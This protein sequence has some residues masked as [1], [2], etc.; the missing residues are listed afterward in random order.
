MAVSVQVPSVLLPYCAGRSELSVAAGTVRSALDEIEREHPRLY[1]CLCDETRRLR[2]HVNVFVNS[3]IVPR[4]EI[5][6]AKLT[7]GDV[8]HV[9]QAVSG[10]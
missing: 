4:G 3:A 9:F 6:S 2:P 10:G 7:E 5:D 8:L 1:V